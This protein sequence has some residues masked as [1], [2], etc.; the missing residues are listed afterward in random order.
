MSLQAS[1][2]LKE[3]AHIFIY[4]KEETFYTYYINL[5]YIAKINII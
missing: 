3:I 1:A 4:V 5:V 2:S